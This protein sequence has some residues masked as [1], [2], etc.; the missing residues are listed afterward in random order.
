MCRATAVI[1]RGE[2]H[3]HVF[4]HIR[5][6]SLTVHTCSQRLRLLLWSADWPTPGRVTSQSAGRAAGRLGGLLSGR[7]LGETASSR[8]AA[9]LLTSADRQVE[10]DYA[11]VEGE[12]STCVHLALP[13][14]Q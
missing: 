14:V 6:E 9:S 11:A 7:G 4:G 3:R 13:V 5:G 10:V 8:A 2:G 1:I 12:R